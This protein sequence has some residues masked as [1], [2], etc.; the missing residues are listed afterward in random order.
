MHVTSLKSRSLCVDERGA[1]SR[2]ARHPHLAPLQRQL[3]PQ[4]RS[5]ALHTSLAPYLSA[6]ARIDPVHAACLCTRAEYARTAATSECAGSCECLCASSL[7]DLQVSKASRDQKKCGKTFS[8]I[9]GALI[10]EIGIPCAWR[11][12]MSLM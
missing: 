11:H 10:L 4:R 3:P 1:R 8:T 12:P 9:A 5:N 6:P 2:R 7:D